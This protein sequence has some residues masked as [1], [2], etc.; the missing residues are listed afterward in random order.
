MWS[1]SFRDRIFDIEG[2]DFKVVRQLTEDDDAEV[3][4]RKVLAIAKRQDKKYLLKIRYQLDPEDC[5]IEDL[6]KT[7]KVAEQHYCHEVEAIDLLSTHGYGPKYLNH[8][9]HEQPDW[10]PFPGG[11]L[12]FIVMEFPP[13]KNVDDIREELTDTQRRSIR[14][15]LAHLLEL[16]RQNDYKLT[17]QHPSYLH[18][19]ARADRLYLVDLA[20]LGYTN[21]ATSYP[22]D[23]ESPYVTAFNIW[24]KE[25]SKPKRTP[26]SGDIPLSHQPIKKENQPPRK[27]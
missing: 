24:R 8:E 9:T 12:E 20:G 10:M 22:I 19:D 13:G 14:K 27:T 25:Y 3:G 6:D 17:E 18:Y 15:Q 1:F 5:D 26:K 2:E 4:E 16:M 21:S 11:Y 23:E 7:L